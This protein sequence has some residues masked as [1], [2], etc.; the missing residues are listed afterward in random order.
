MSLR[1]NGKPDVNAP[2]A[3]SRRPSS[4]STRPSR[5]T[6]ASSLP[7]WRWTTSSW[8]RTLLAGRSTTWCS[9][10]QPE[11]CA[12]G[13][14]IMT[15]CPPRTWSAWCRSRCGPGSEGHDGQPGVR[16]ARAAGHID[17][18]PVK[19]LDTVKEATKDAK[20]QD[21]AIGAET[22]TNWTESPRPRSQPG[23]RAGVESAGVGSATPPDVQRDDLQRPRAELPTT[24]PGPGCS[25]CGPSAR[26]DL[27][28]GR[29]QHHRDE[30]HGIGQLRHPVLPGVRRRPRGSCRLHPR[31]SGRIGSKRRPRP[32]LRLPAKPR[33][34]SA[35][36]LPRRPLLG[37]SARRDVAQLVST[38]LPRLGSGLIP[39]S[40]L[41]ASSGT[42]PVV[43]RD[44]SRALA[45][46]ASGPSPRRHPS[47][48]DGAPSSVIH[49]ASAI[50]R[51]RRHIR[52]AGV[53]QI[54]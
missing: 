23:P 42:G 6:A 48:R 39:S 54:L 37:S 35:A 51:L 20:E 28:R 8:S 9:P 43:V 17:D 46:L 16:D 44:P 38:T 29:G 49:E 7:R 4:F 10:C 31:G 24:R 47:A 32:R 34:A 11:R 2:P 1:R 5:R 26:S 3:P 41:S 12:I 15:I 13:S 52:W 25:G 27:R 22:L 36:H 30:L 53:E 45:T 18:D 50:V 40:A 14:R 19:R 33:H 21:K